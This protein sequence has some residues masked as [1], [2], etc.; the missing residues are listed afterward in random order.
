[1]NNTSDTAAWIDHLAIRTL[2]DRYT[3]ALNGRIGA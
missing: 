1:M 2:I 3:D